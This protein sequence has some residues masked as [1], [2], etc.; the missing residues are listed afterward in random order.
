MKIPRLR[1]PFGGKDKQFFTVIDLGSSSVKEGIYKR[2]TEITAQKLIGMGNQGQGATSMYGGYIRDLDSVIDMVE[3]ALEEA[4][5]QAGVTP[6]SAIIGLSGGALFS[7]GFR[8]RTNRTNPDEPIREDEFSLVADHI[9]DQTIKRSVEKLT[10]QYGAAVKRV[11]TSFTQYKV[12]GA[13]V[14][15]PM[16]ITGT[17][18]EVSVLHYFAEESHIHLINSLA[19]QVGV[20]VVS[21]VDTAVQTAVTLSKD[22]KQCVLIDAGGSV[23]SVVVIS[24]GKVERVLPIFMGGDDYVWALEKGMNVNREMAISLMHGYTQGN[25]DDERARNVRRSFEDMSDWMVEAISVCVS[26]MGLT[27]IPPS[28]Y[29]TGDLRYV[30]ELSKALSAYPWVGMPFSGDVIIETLPSKTPSLDALSLLSPF[31]L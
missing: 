16:G 13:R 21:L 4:S 12:D 14:E 5:L 9:E 19:N 25:L 30:R 29:L 20:E 18:L 27:H 7:E 28:L 2:A 15:T 31:V 24:D 22:K 10:E 3:I 26:S 8:V 17:Q 1:L 23:T 11:E 6:R